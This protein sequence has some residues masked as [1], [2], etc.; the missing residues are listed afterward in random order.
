MDQDPIPRPAPVVLT[1]GS[2][3]H[4]FIR[5]ESFPLNPLLASF[6][7]AE[8]A[9]AV[10]MQDQVVC[11]SDNIL[12]STGLSNLCHGLKSVHSGFEVKLYYKRGV[13]QVIMSHDLAILPTP[14]MAAL[15]SAV[16][17]AAHAQDRTCRAFHSA[18]QALDR[19]KAR[20]LLT[21][22]D[23]NGYQISLQLPHLRGVPS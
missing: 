10:Q 1:P 7:P 13:I 4:H 17:P 3:P 12:V 23:N 6:L 19:V 22:T 11:K 16:L 21:G 2:I 20:I 18:R 5:V 8:Q 15:Q 14:C 9:R